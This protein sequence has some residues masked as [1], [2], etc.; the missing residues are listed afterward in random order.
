MAK[1]KTNAEDMDL[2]ELFST[3]ASETGG[4]VLSDL[5]SVKFRIDTGNLAI[6]Y[7][8]SGKCIPGGVPGGRITEAF[9]GEASGKSLIGANLLGSMQKQGG[10]P[11]ILDCENATNGEFMKKISHL[12]LKRVLRYSPPSLERAFRQI[13][14]TTKKIREREKE[15]KLERKPILFVFD[16]L[17][18]PPCERELKENNLPLDYSV[19]DWK[20]IVG[21]QEQPGERAKVISNEMRKLQAMVK[22]Q[23]VTVYLINQTRD[24]I[25]VMYGSPETTPGGNAVKF[26]ASLRIRTAA[27]KKIEH[28]K[29]EKFSGINM[30]VKNIKNRGFRPFVIAD[31]VKLYFENGIDPMSG[32]LN[33]L[34]EG[35]RV[36]MKSGG[37]YIVKPAYLPEGTTEYKFK[38][39]K[40]ENRLPS[41]V[42]I[43]CPKLVDAETSDEVEEY[44]GFWGAGL[45]A[46]E[47][48]EYGEK[49]VDFDADG[50][51]FET[52][53]YDNE[54]DEEDTSENEE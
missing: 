28:K 16:S 32:L 35:E 4:D 39:S 45:K 6:N 43:D 5:E 21:R 41:Q 24:K 1:K 15:L 46:S 33:C 31:D 17:T 2:D 29:L 26:Y 44:L 3:L 27:K 22:E 52:E 9:G 7:S 10:W 23:D 51:P 48:G 25:G 49:T 37:N 12:N 18:V 36:E 20:K 11:V 54:S 40:A 38:A 53:G 19:A 34:L 8:C 14:V 30:Q 42:I 50:N 13:H 47:S